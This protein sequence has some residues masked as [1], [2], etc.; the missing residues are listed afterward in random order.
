MSASNSDHVSFRVRATSSLLVS[1]TSIRDG[2]PGG[3]CYTPIVKDPHCWARPRYRITDEA[4]DKRV[5]WVSAGYRGK[6]ANRDSS[7]PN[8]LPLPPITPL[9]EDVSLLLGFQIAPENQPAEADLHRAE[10]GM[11]AHG[12]K[13]VS[14][15][16]Q[17]DVPSARRPHW[18]PLSKQGEGVT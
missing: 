2:G 3:G 8:T 12:E 6:R 13:Y 14:K 15:M 7:P 10:D 16:Q 5:K 11:R 17:A 1:I 4:P 9:S 18:K